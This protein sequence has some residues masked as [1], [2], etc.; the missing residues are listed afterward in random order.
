MKQKLA[1]T[2]IQSGVSECS[3][4]PSGKL[5]TV[6]PRVKTPTIHRLMARWG[7]PY[8]PLMSRI[9]CEE[10]EGRQQ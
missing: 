8:R 3:M 10:E 6:A 5:M 4:K 9:P 2:A 7:R 1:Q